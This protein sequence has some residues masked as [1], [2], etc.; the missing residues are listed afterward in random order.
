VD[1][2]GG[3]DSAR[4]SRRRRDA[5]ANGGLSVADLLARHGSDADVPGHGGSAGSA[6]SAG[7]GVRHRLG[8]WPADGQEPADDFERLQPRAGRDD[9]YTARDDSHA[10]RDDDYAGWGDDGFDGFDQG[11]PRGDDQHSEGY[12]DD[13]HGEQRGD[14]QFG[15]H[16]LREDYLVPYRTRDV[17]QGMTDRLFPAGTVFAL[18]GPSE[19]N[20]SG[21]VIPGGEPDAGDALDGGAGGGRRRKAAH[22]LADALDTGQDAA[23]GSAAGLEAGLGA[24]LGAGH[25]AGLGDAEPDD[26]PT[27]VVPRTVLPT[28]AEHAG[29]DGAAD[30]DAEPYEDYD[31]AADGSEDT[32]RTGAVA[33]PAGSGATESTDALAAE[34][35]AAEPAE[36]ATE[37]DPDEESGYA[38]RTRRIDE[39]LTRLTAIHAGLGLE[40]TERVSRSQRLAVIDRTGGPPKDA[41]AGASDDEPL[42]HQGLL[43]AGRVAALVV[44]ALLFV[45]TAAGWGTQ[46]WLNTKLPSVNAL[47]PDA[48]TIVD[49]AGQAGDQ[50][51]LLVGVDPKT[52]GQSGG[53]QPSGPSPLPD[54]PA[55]PPQLALTGPAAGGPGVSGGGL[56]SIMLVHVPAKTDRAV[57]LSFPAGLAVDRPSCD[58]WDPVSGGLPG[59]TSPAQTGVPLSAAYA[60]GGPRCLTKAVQQLTGLSVNHYTGLDVTGLASVVDSVRGVPVCLAGPAPSTDSASTGSGSAPSAGDPTVLGGAQAVDFVGVAPAAASLA[61]GGQAQRQQLFVTALLRKATSDQVLLHLGQLRGFVSAFGDHSRSDNASLGQLATLAQSLQQLD[62]SKIFLAT[63]PTAA[64][65]DAQG[66]QALAGDPAKALFE[67]IR[68]DQTLPGE[69]AATDGPSEDDSTQALKAGTLPPSAVSVTVRNGSARKGLAGQVADQLRPLGFTIATVADAPPTDGGRTIIRHSADRADQAAV[70]AASI[71]S[72]VSET[73]PGSAGLLDLVVGDSFDGQVKAS[74][75][76]A[77]AAG[78]ATGPG[79]SAPVGLRTLSSATGSCP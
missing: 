51:Y 29:P 75:A 62:P 28:G 18:N 43:R 25:G 17:D 56:D 79:N 21:P 10:G 65:P 49:L 52:A 37:A 61:G 39:S 74:P 64:A 50:N 35:R 45:G 22:A 3:F 57:V 26:S 8:E 63:V 66:N 23:P 7:S 30:P 34:P 60:V 19:S 76:A 5:D 36:R 59:G 16:D 72:A 15:H 38:L 14:R 27:A 77:T 4:R 24:G 55:L 70:L 73:V 11:E 47:D 46:A 40:M 48:T 6:G 44:A 1:D 68:V 33:P 9:G 67:A 2:D 41:T 20:G 32:V 13:G 31:D 69:T 78:T 42:R 54:Q 12:G 71:P 58:R 53:G